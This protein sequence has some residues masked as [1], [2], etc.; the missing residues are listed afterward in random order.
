MD[1][2]VPLFQKERELVI[3]R[4]ENDGLIKENKPIYIP[5][6]DWQ[7]NLKL[8]VLGPKD[9]KVIQNSI[10]QGV[11]CIAVSFVESKEDII[12]VKKVLGAKG[13]HIKL[14]AKI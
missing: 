9:I 12:Y 6:L 7:K 13:A 14:L 2:T 5:D 10:Q 8:S 3:C 4:V 1:L 11:E